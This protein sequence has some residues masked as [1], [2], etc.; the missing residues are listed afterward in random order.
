ML[1]AKL[2]IFLYRLVDDTLWFCRQVRIHSRVRT[3]ILGSKLE[4]VV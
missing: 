1:A 2:A 3:P 4:S